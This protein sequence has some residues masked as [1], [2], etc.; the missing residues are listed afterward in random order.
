MA[1]EPV[2]CWGFEQV[3]FGE[4]PVGGAFGGGVGDGVDQ[5][6]GLGFELQFCGGCIAIIERTVARV[7][8]TLSP[9]KAAR[10]ASRP[11]AAPSRASQLAASQASWIGVGN[12]HSGARR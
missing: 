8:P 12:C 5:Y 1:V 6:L 2:Q 4:I 7:A 9:A 11:W 3:A 10:V